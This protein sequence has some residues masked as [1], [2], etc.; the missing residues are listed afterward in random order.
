VYFVRNANDRA[1]R[2]DATATQTVKIYALVVAASAALQMSAAHAQPADTSAWTCEFCPFATGSSGSYQI[3]ATDVSDDSAYLGDAT[4]YSEKGVYANIDGEGD[5]ASDTQQLRWT[6]ED[7]ALDSR[8]AELTGGRQGTYQYSLAYREIPRT[9]YFTTNTIFLQSANDTLSLPAGWV[10]APLTSGFTELEQNLVARD[11]KSER[12][13]IDIGGRYMPANRFRFSANYRRQEHDGLGVAGGSYFTQSSL[14]PAPFDYVTDEVDLSF[15]L[16]SDNGYLSLAWYLSNFDNSNDKLI[17]ENPFTAA[18]GAESAA[19]DAPPDN[20]FQQLSL[21]GSY[22]FPEFHTVMAFSAAF[23]RL[24]QDAEFLPYTTNPNLA[25]DPL[26]R[27]NLDGEID[28]TRLSFTL[29]SNVSSKAQIKLAYRFDERDNKT[30]QDLWN[31]VITDTFISGDSETNI[32]YSFERS[33]FNLSANYDLFDNVRLYAGYDRKRIDRDFQEVAEQTEDSGWGRL[34]WR[35]N[36]SINLDIRGGAAERDIDRY[37]ET[38]AVNLGQNPLLRKYNLAYRYRTFGDLTLSVAPAESPFSMTINAL[39]AEDDYS[40]SQLGLTK[41]EELNLTADFSWMLANNA[42]FYITGGYENLESEQI[43]SE[44]LVSP[45]WRASNNDDFLTA[46]LGFR[47]RQIA[48]KFDVQMNYTRS[49]GTTE[50]N[51][52]SAAGGISRFPALE[53]TFDYLHIFNL[54]YQS[55]STEDWA[56]DSVGPATVPVV[57]TLGAEPYDDE[58]WLFG[59]GLRYS[60]GIARE[61]ATE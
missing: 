6:L 12:R 51:V 18:P 43:G 29:N 52:T 60:F 3:G 31:R 19:L 30:A 37:N 9:Q 33:T 26:P 25:A 4:G 28:T 17:W 14:L 57:L 34:R 49:E 32:P 36:A 20:N 16:A 2:M 13:I 27:S 40:Q 5:Y 53:S 56:L 59:L 8:F 48:D 39:I 35:P 22:S 21:S 61:T 10:H 38:L 15:R 1:I 45:D 7:L 50:I 58:V 24:E 42:S 41:G 44:L 55:F 11:I 47:L 46:G 54:R 23:G